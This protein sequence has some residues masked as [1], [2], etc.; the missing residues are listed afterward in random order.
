MKHTPGPYTVEGSHIV[1]AEPNGEKR[2]NGGS[3]IAVVYGNDAEANAPLLAAA[4]E[5][6]EVLLDLFEQVHLVELRDGERADTA[7]A[8]ALLHRLGAR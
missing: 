5:L 6:L 8:E 2:K 4:P 3:S 7:L 1:A